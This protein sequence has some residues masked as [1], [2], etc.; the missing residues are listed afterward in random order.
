[1]TWTQVSSYLNVFSL[2]NNVALTVPP[3]HLQVKLSQR[4]REAF[5]LVAPLRRRLVGHWHRSTR[6][7]CISLKHKSLAAP[8]LTGGWH[9]D[10]SVSGT[11]QVEMRG[12]SGNERT[13][14]N[15]PL[16]AGLSTLL[17]CGELAFNAA[18]WTEQDSHIG[19]WRYN[20]LNP[21]SLQTL[22]PYREALWTSG[23]GPPLLPSF[24]KM[25]HV[26]VGDKTCHIA[27][28]LICNTKE[29]RKC[30]TPRNAQPIKMFSSS[31]PRLLPAHRFCGIWIKHVE[32]KS[33]ITLEAREQSISQ[34][35]TYIRNVN[36]DC[37]SIIHSLQHRNSIMNLKKRNS[38]MLAPRKIPI[39]N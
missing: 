33:L 2:Y 25:S 11:H 13:H 36:L 18:L 4:R 22:H 32:T 34:Y 8:E 17:H 30:S 39:F 15:L 26:R 12:G 6:H 3:L 9:G 14:T 35:F 38:T 31:I 28:H 37:W 5:T 27:R 10:D 24:G 16:W 19:G 21:Q 20:L 1:M 23:Y 29:E 7:S